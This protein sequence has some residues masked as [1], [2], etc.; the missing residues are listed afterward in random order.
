[1][2]LGAVCP[3][4]LLFSVDIYVD[5][6]LGPYRFAEKDAWAFSD[7]GLE[8]EVVLVLPLLAPHLHPV[9]L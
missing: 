4:V 7:V 8:I 5:E 3:L 2:G 6:T 9:P 1:M